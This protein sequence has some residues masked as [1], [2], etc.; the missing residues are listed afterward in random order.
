[1]AFRST[2]CSSPPQLRARRPGRRDDQGAP[3]PQRLDWFDF[4]R[5]LERA[6]I[7]DIQ[8]NRHRCVMVARV[9]IR[10]CLWTFGPWAASSARRSPTPARSGHELAG[11]CAG[12]GNPDVHHLTPMLWHRWIIALPGDLRFGLTFLFLT[13]HNQAAEFGLLRLVRLRWGYL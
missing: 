3:A 8:A 13:R 5:S 1:I 2:D 9:I 10:R 4:V 6:L 11:S 12:A 7:A